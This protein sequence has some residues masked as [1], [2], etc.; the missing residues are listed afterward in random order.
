MKPKRDINFKGPDSMETIPFGASFPAGHIVNPNS[1]YRTFY[2]QFDQTNCIHCYL[3]YVF[4]P[5]GAIDRDNGKFTVDMDYCKGCGVCANEC[6]K[7]CI[8]MVKEGE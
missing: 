3:C 1:G 2:P 6:P 7:K 5:E 8:T 4:C